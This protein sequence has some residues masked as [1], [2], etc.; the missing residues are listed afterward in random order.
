MR[1]LACLTLSLALTLALAGCP[2]QPAQPTP[3]SGG[4]P[5]GDAKVLNLYIWSEYIDP[6]LLEE[7][8]QRTGT[9]VQVSLFESSEEMLGKLENAAGASQYDL[10]VA[11]NQ[12]IPALV[13]LKLVQPLD[14]ALLPH[15]DQLAKRFLN[16]PYDPGAC[17]SVAYQWGTV[18]LLYDKQK[19][20]DLAPSWSVL[21]DPAKQVGS[22]VLID[23]A[24]D[25]LGI[26]LKY[27]GHSVN[28]TDPEQL[29]AAGKLL[30][31]AKASERC[32]GFEGGVGGKNKVAGGLADLA[33]VWNGD[34]GRAIAEDT[35][36]RL[37][38]VVP[39]EGSIWWCD[40]LVVTSGAKNVAGAHALIDF[41]LEPE[42]GARLST[43][44]KY[45]T[46]NTGALALLPEAERQNPVVYPS[47]EVEKSLEAMKDVGDG[48]RLY[49]EVWTAVKAR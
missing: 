27:L 16:P 42:V 6:K 25:Q 32:I 13:R 28:T 3:G 23:D 30:L 49:D 26:A 2:G 4:A 21:L 37:G 14:I 47:A 17:Y 38:F 45:A 1:P 46:P 33:V 8:T 48:T 29:Q 12:A 7:F 11:P 22:F 43:F 18:G 39:R 19:H 5:G 40:A 9:K 41:L 20:P 35:K 24:R 36:G 44:T 31:A 34:A 15:R 10:V